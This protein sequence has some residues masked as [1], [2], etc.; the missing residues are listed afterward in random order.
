ME[1]NLK[2]FYLFLKNSSRTEINKPSSWLGRALAEYFIQYLLFPIF[3]IIPSFK[4]KNFLPE[5][6]EP[7]NG[8]WEVFHLCCNSKGKG[9]KLRK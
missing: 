4:N 2:G 8:Y 3:R 7:K 5:P 6:P 1:N 9:G